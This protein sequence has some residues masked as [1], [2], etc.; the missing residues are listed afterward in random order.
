MEQ[1]R[2]S[3]FAVAALVTFSGLALTGPSARAD[4]TDGPTP[5]RPACGEYRQLRAMLAERFGEEPTSA[6]LAENGTI[7]QVFAS[8][9]AATWTMVKVEATGRA[10]VFA[11]GRHWEQ[12]NQMLGDKP[13]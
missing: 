12:Q 11:V 6:G 13:A 1:P 9:T 3:I 8:A 10:C 7:M 2:R 5:D 4:R